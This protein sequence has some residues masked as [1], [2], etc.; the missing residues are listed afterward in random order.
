MKKALITVSTITA[1]LAIAF[2]FLS[3]RHIDQEE[4]WRAKAERDSM[5]YERE[6]IY[7][8]TSAIDSMRARLRESEMKLQLENSN[9]RL[10]L[11]RLRDEQ[12][13]EILATRSLSSFPEMERAFKSA[14][15]SIAPSTKVGD[16]RVE[17]LELT[18]LMVPLSFSEVILS[19]RTESVF[20]QEQ[21]ALLENIDS[22]NQEI[23]HLKDSLLVLEEQKS[24]EF[25]KGYDMAYAKYDSLNGLYVNLL[26][27][28]QISI[29]SNS[30]T[31]IL[32]GAIGLA[33][34]SAIP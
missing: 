22:L 2:T 11:Q 8:V 17:G 30:T 25:Q 24:V 9:N 28:P 16:I 32:A 4:I 6:R 10:A 13:N 20:Q 12:E 26:E 29:F 7:S 34:G 31:A 14:F 5:R 19:Y 33:A 15:P 21:I 23:F 3:A 27:N 18:Y 1:I